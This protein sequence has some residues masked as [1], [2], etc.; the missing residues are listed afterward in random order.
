MNLPYVYNDFYHNWSTFDVGFDLPG[1]INSSIPF[2]DTTFDEFVENVP[3][4]D[5][6]DND[7]FYRHGR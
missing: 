5:N 1:S 2:I 7:T 4:M 6:P 3:A